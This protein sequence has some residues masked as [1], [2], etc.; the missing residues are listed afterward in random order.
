MLHLSVTRSIGTIIVK[1]FIELQRNEFPLDYVGSNPHRKG[2]YF[3]G[4]TSDE[5][6]V[7]D[8]ALSVFDC[9]LCYMTCVCD[10]IVLDPLVDEPLVFILVSLFI[11]IL[12]HSIMLCLFTRGYI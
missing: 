8:L 4:T 3:G 6:N 10:V 12:V 1:Q 9:Y 2:E 5:N 7:M 11:N